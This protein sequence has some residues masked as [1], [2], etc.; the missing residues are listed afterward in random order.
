M[1]VT[2]LSR[3]ETLLA[4]HPAVRE[5]CLLCIS[6]QQQLDAGYGT[7]LAPGALYEASSTKS[8]NM[9]PIKGRKVLIN[10]AST[11]IGFALAK[12]CLAEDMDVHIASSNSDKIANATE[13][14][15]SA[16]PN[17]RVISHV[18]KLG[19]TMPKPFSSDSS[20]RLLST[21]LWITLA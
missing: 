15:A 5:P 20:L 6:R 11:T 21:A 14:L 7:G 17:R 8:T 12:L 19:V 4:Q 10:G 13:T 18:A 9:P 1:L 16:N 3:F 2:R